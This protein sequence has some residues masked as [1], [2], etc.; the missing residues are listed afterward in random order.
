MVLTIHGER[1]MQ[2]AGAS[3]D[4]I[5]LIVK[6]NLLIAITSDILFSPNGAN[7]NPYGK[8]YAGGLKIIMLLTFVLI[9]CILVTGCVGQMKNA[10]VNA[11]TVNSTITFTPSSNTTTVSNMSNSTKPPGLNG[12]VKISLNTWIGEFPVSVDTIDVGLVS[13]SRPLVLMLGEGNHTVEVCCGV[14]CEQENI[15]TGFGIQR[16]IDFSERLKKDCEFLEPTVRIVDYSQSGDHITVNVE[17]INPTTRDLPMSAE[18]SCGYSYI[19]SRSNNR[20]GSS[21]NGHLFSTLK[22]GDRIMQTLNLKLGSGY[23]YIYEM[24]IITD[25]SSK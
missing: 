14:V 18:I 19:D 10:A 15:T 8:F 11:T 6:V 24:P 5:S 3:P 17:F 20:V 4:F 2:S 1:I 7:D 21:S 25:V 23:S 12:S 9:G 13:T 16:H 22:A